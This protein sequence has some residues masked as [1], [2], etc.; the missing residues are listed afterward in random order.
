MSLERSAQRRSRKVS[1]VLIVIGALCTVGASYNFW[2][3]YSAADGVILG[4]AVI[5]RADGK[6]LLWARGPRDPDEGEWFDITDSP[7][8]PNGYE[9]GIGKDTIPAIDHPVY[10]AIDDRDRLEKAGI[11]QDTVVFGFAYEDDARAFP[12]HILNRHELVNDTI[13]GKPVTVGW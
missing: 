12:I 1:L 10:A 3:L 2:N 6:R 13:G 7:L 5:E 4:G 9:Y 11:D 8:D